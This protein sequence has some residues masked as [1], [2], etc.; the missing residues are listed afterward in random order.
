MLL[1]PV[2]PLPELD[3][4]AALTPANEVEADEVWP[5][6]PE[7]APAKDAEVAVVVAEDAVLG[8]TMRGVPELVVV[9]VVESLV[10]VIV[11]SCEMVPA[12]EL[13]EP[14]IEGTGGI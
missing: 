4:R 2:E 13:L 1:L 11:L 7:T 14:D 9:V 10:W 12:V 8:A 3:E 6:G 5:V